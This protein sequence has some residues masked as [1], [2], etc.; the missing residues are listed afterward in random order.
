MP[1]LRGEGCAV[2]ASLGCS[3][4]ASSC[5]APATA[6]TNAPKLAPTPAIAPAAGPSAGC[7]SNHG[8]S[9]D[10]TD[11]DA[12]VSC[13]RSSVML[14]GALRSILRAIG[15][16]GSTNREHRQLILRE[17]GFV[18]IGQAFLSIELVLEIAGDDAGQGSGAGDVAGNGARAAVDD[19]IGHGYSRVMAA[20]GAASPVPES[21]N[22]TLQCGTT[23]AKTTGTP[24]DINRGRRGTLQLVERSPRT[25]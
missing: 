17:A 13:V 9:A 12:T 11:Q 25:L 1:L 23:G 14:R 22:V 21:S 5:S 7:R 15:F 2:G 24:N 16:G 8:C 3:A 20:T 6:S 10:G 4:L 19:R 18:E